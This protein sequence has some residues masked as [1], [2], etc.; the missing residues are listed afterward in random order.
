MDS[1]NTLPT[2][3]ARKNIFSI[4][5]NVQVPSTYYTLT[6]NGKPKAVILSVKEFES[7]RETLEVVKDFPNLKKDIADARKDL[8]GGKTFLLQAFLKKRVHAISRHPAKK[9]SKRS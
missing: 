4:T 9:S 5:K 8:K 1:K 3:E 7:W 6:E 2:S